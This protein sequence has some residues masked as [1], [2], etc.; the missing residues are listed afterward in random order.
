MR[1]RPSESERL[2]AR[3]RDNEVSLQHWGEG[4]CFFC[5]STVSYTDIKDRVGV[6]SQTVLCPH[7]GIDAVITLAEFSEAQ[8]ENLQ[9]TLHQLHADWFGTYKPMSKPGNDQ[10]AAL[11]MLA[12]RSARAQGLWDN[13]RT[14]GT[15]SAL[16]RAFL[17]L[18]D[19]AESRNIDLAESVREQ[20]KEDAQLTV[21]GFS[22]WGVK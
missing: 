13:G 21:P 17:A 5:E 9:D 12:H 14:M 18:A 7:C 16:A 20:L 6:D 8:V 19:L 1:I 11:Q 4:A 3:C 22:E 15:A 10:L 2:H